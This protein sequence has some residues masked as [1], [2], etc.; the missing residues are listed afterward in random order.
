MMY[1]NYISA[2]CI[3]LCFH[4]ASAQGN[5]STL[6]NTKEH[7]EQA[8]L[9][10]KGMLEGTVPL[11]FK[12]AVFVTENAFL[13]NSLSYSAFN[14]R[15]QLLIERCETIK[16]SDALIYDGKDREE[17]L[18]YWSVYMVMKQV[19]S[20]EYDSGKVRPLTPFTYDFDDF[21]GERDWTKMF[22]S[23]LLQSTSGNCHSLPFLYK[24]LCE[25]LDAKAYLAMAPS[26]IYIKQWTKKTGWFNTE[27]T[28]GH[29]P[30]DAWIMAS[31][32]VHLSAVQ[33]RLYMDTLSSKQSIALCLID[34]AK[35]Y[36]RKYGKES[37]Q[38]FIERC[39]DV[40]LTYYPNYINGLLLRAET[41]K[42][43][44]ES[45]M[46]KNKAQYPSDLFNNPEGKSLFSEMENLYIQIHQLGYRT[47]PKEMYENWLDELSREREKYSNKE[48]STDFKK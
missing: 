37:D 29:F 16:K 42:K 2:L 40:C 41:K 19:K 48:I 22:V 33:N 34:L 31:G 8:Y 32:Y 4:N 21:W 45:L 7:Y 5:D 3:F 23:K 20:F 36:E 28:S 17:V 26:H 43:Q 12:R 18:K 15:I 10:L 1:Y 35:G 38:E 6:K 14:E 11:S 27:L 9:E 24:I 13:D 47:M 30:I 39:A 25:E 44:F 46:A